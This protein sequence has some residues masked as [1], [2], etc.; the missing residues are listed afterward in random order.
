MGTL[1]LRLVELKGRAFYWGKREFFRKRT[2]KGKEHDGTR[3]AGKL[4]RLSFTIS[5]M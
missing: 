1:I 3:N 2:E 4:V 5:W